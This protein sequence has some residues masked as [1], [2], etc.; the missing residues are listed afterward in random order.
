MA[1]PAGSPTLLQATALETGPEE[2]ALMLGG[3]LLSSMGIP[4]EEVRE[5][6][7]GSGQPSLLPTL[8]YSLPSFTPCPL[9]LTT[10]FTYRPLFPPRPLFP[11]Q[12]LF[13]LYSH[14]C[15]PPCTLDRLLPLVPTT[16]SCR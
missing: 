13:T 3:A 9:L 6:Q 2:S 12:P 8:V 7:R 5:E 1:D 11:S 4:K 10:L 16:R 14:E 15:A